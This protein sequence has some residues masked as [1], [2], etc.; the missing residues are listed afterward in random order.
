MSPAPGSEPLPSE[1]TG[2]IPRKRRAARGGTADSSVSFES[3][4]AQGVKLSQALSGKTWTDYNLHDPGVT[5]LEQLCYALTDLVYRADFPVADH[6]QAPGL[7][8]I[9]FAG[10]SLHPP[11]AA[12]PCRATSAADYRRVL[13]DQVPGLDD[14]R[15]CARPPGSATGVT[16]SPLRGV[17]RLQLKLSQGQVTGDDLRVAEARAAYR[18]NRNLCEDIGAQV[19][20]I[21]DDWCDLRLDVE[22]TGP[23]SAVDVLADIYAR[24]ARHLAQ[25]LV[26]HSL[27][28]L[29]AAGQ[30]L[31]QIHTGPVTAQGFAQDSG[32]PPEEMLFVSDLVALAKGV[33]GVHEVHGLALRPDGDDTARSSALRWRDADSALRLRVPGVTPDVREADAV[34]DLLQREVRLR[35]RGSLVTVSPSELAN[36]LSDLYAASRTRARGHAAHQLAALPH[37]RH[38]DLRRYAS[39]Q[40]DFPAVYGLGHR[41]MTASATPRE[42]AQALQLQT[43][44]VLFEQVMA[45]SA[46]Q[47]EHLRDLF[48]AGNA[49][50]PSY[51]WQMLDSATVPGLDDIYLPAAGEGVTTAAEDVARAASAESVRA[52]VQAE[53]YERRDPHADRKSRAFDHLLALHGETYSQNSMRQFCDYHS[54]A[55]LEAALL[56]NKASFLQDIVRLTRD[57]AAGLDYAQPSWGEARG[58]TGLQRRVS[59][60]LGFHHAHSRPL[61]QAVRKQKRKLHAAGADQ[62]L[63]PADDPGETRATPPHLLPLNRNDM[64]ADLEQM[65]FLRHPQL[66]EALLRCGLYRERYRLCG[67]PDDDADARPATGRQKMVLGPDERGRWWPLGEF[68]SREAAARAADSLRRFLLHLNHE[69]E[70]LHVV[71]HVLLRPVGDSPEHARLDGLPDDFHA[72]R[73]TAVFPAWT[74]R[75][76]QANFQRLADETVRINCPAHVAS[77]CLWLGFDAMLR[78]EGHYADWL[79]AKIDFCAAG[80]QSLDES[81]ASAAIAQRL[82]RAACRVIECLRDVWHARSGPAPAD[83]HA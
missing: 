31:E 28:E 66:S 5:I 70:G 36:R 60:L 11:D 33:D 63:G 42:K 79:Q 77:G 46:A 18:A 37:G 23:R 39:V 65:P 68:E 4:R 75:C 1:A 27:G 62:S 73:L 50:G 55:E 8:G 78:F 3:L 82:N 81:R 58:G 14:A 52:H 80:S 44:L 17:Y 74:A 20:L 38:R 69:S 10:L 71:E 15:L 2:T 35:R 67:T 19:D 45:H 51:W 83:A 22:L 40:N 56:E 24:C 34:R 7:D 9:D 54:P 29:L 53:V 76:A 64:Q 48:S 57:R 26:F 43:Y 41:G 25:G 72:L 16:L 61:T 59:H 13:L 6:L 47:I 21:K 49:A 32:E 30:T 12:F